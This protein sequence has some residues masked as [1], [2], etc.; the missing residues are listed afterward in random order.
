MK[1]HKNFQPQAK[2]DLLTSQVFGHMKS[3]QVQEQANFTFSRLECTS[4][5]QN[6]A[7]PNYE[8]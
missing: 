7:Q 8:T 4:R 3:P 2:I 1:Y 6:I 5:I